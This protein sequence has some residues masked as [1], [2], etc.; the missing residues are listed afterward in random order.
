MAGAL[1][2]HFAAATYHAHMAEVDV[3]PETGKVTVLRYVVVQDVGRAINPQMIEGQIHG[4][5]LQGVGY[6]L[7]EHLRL[8]DGGDV[9]DQNLET[10][11]LPGP[12]DAPPIEIAIC[13][14][15][16]P[17]GPLGAKGAAEPSIIPVAAV[18]ACAVADAIGRPVRELPLTPFAV[19]AALRG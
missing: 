12:A 5:V 2:T 6:A 4:G 16:C 11:R 14:N 19:L 10:Y 1:F 9:L 13:E 8:G 3:D 18:I 7:F 17:Y 15:P